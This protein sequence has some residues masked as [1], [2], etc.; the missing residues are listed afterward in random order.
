MTAPSDPMTLAMRVT[1]WLPM[2]VFDVK[3]AR[4]PLW[5]FSA[6]SS[7]KKLRSLM[8]DQMAFHSSYWVVASRPEDA[9]NQ[10]GVSLEN[11]RGRTAGRVPVDVEQIGGWPARTLV[12]G[13]DHVGMLRT[14]VAENPVQQEPQPALRA[15]GHERV[16]VLLARQAEALDALPDGVPV[17]DR[18]RAATMVYLDHI[19]THPNAWAA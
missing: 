8:L 10:R 5:R 1:S 3:W 9:T 19:A 15:G 11:A 13:A 14:D 12:E 2:K 17:H 6:Q 18:I 16:E 7:S 4:K